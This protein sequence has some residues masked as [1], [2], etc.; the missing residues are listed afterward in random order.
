MRVTIDRP[1]I[2]HIDFSDEPFW[3][4]SMTPETRPGKLKTI[5]DTRAWTRAFFDG[6]VRG[7]WAELK[8]LASEASKSQ[9]DV[10]IHIFVKMWP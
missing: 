6:A 3:D 9:P 10:S 8:R 2:T 4:G 5:A 1:G 7:E